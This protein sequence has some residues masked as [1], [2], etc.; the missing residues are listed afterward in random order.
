MDRKKHTK[1]WT[2]V[3]EILDILF[4]DKSND[5]EGTT[6]PEEVEQMKTCSMLKVKAHFMCAKSN[7]NPF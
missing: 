4:S 7:L 2:D 1:I 5:L 6:A 3:N